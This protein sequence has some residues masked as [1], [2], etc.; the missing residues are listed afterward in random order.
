MCCCWEQQPVN[1]HI[2]LDR[3]TDYYCTYVICI[4]Y[5]MLCGACS[6]R[7][8]ATCP[9]DLIGLFVRMT[10]IIPIPVETFLPVMPQKGVPCHHGDFSI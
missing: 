10:C 3:V 9:R 7:Y 8:V 2:G 1:V 6:A 4:W 5:C